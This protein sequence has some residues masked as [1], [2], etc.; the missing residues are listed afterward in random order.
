MAG[1]NNFFYLWGLFRGKK[2]DNTHYRTS[3]QIETAIPRLD[4][5]IP[6][7]DYPILGTSRLQNM[8]TS[9]PSSECLKK[10]D[11]T[12]C[13]L[14]SQ[15]ETSI[16]SL[17]NAVPNQD[18]SIPGRSRSQN[19]HSCGP[20]SVCLSASKL[21]HNVHH[22]SN[23]ISSLNLPSISSGRNDEICKPEIPYLEAELPCPEQKCFGLQTNFDSKDRDGTVSFLSIP[24]REEQSNNF[25]VIFLIIA[26]F[27]SLS[28]SC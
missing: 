12:E 21:Y 1:W 23:F 28:I 14:S 27:F 19:M 5:A 16:L 17:D 7:Q 2:V 8:N 10:V 3:S 15:N 18:Y 20:S 9:A 26:R 22:S 11:N 4:D 24:T 13:L 6:D 25:L